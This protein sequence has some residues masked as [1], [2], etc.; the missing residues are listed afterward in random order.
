MAREKKAIVIGTGAGGLTAAAYLSK[1]G[2]ETLALEQAMHVGGY[3]NPFVRKGYHFDPGVHYVGEVNPGQTIHS[4]LAPLGLDMQQIFCELDPDGFDLYRFPNHSAKM[5]RGL[6]RYQQ[7]LTDLFPAQARP[8]QRYFNLVNDIKEGSSRITAISMRGPRLKDLKSIKSIVPVIRYLRKTYG[9]LLNNLIPDPALR[10]ILSGTCGDYG[11]P[12]SQAAALIGIG[13]MMHYGDGAFFPRGGSGRLRDTIMEKATSAGAVFQT[14]TSVEKVLVT[15]GKV[16]GVELE[17][18]ERFEADVVVSAIEPSHTF[19]HLLRDHRLPGRLQRKIKRLKPSLGMFTAY[20]GMKRDLREHGLSACNIWDYASYDIEADYREVQNGLIPRDMSFFLSP[21]SLKDDSGSMAPEGGSTV[22]L[23]TFVP[24]A[25]F[26][27]W[28]HL[29]ANKRGEDYKEFKQK[30]GEQLLET[31]DKRW[32][33]VL[34]DF[35]VKE[36]ST[37]ITNTYYVRAVQGGTYGPAQ[38]PDQMPPF[39]FMPTTPIKGLYLAGSGVFGAGVA[40]CL[41]SGMVAASIATKTRF[42]VEN[43]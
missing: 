37:P 7:R 10:A 14:K 1:A 22:E 8:L 2:Y 12:P 23:S 30:I 21:N 6:D 42:R 16:T 3:L 34:G 4:A 40:P 27:K 36:F 17:N 24:Y 11:L 5:C 39:R 43:G 15:N 18:G 35:E 20:L 41:I 28:E 26:R 32:P 25:P 38:T 31:V 29:P 19:G 9:H 13:M 33:G